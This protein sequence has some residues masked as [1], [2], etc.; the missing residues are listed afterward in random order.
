M[1]EEIWEKPGENPVYKLREIW[2]NSRMKS[3]EIYKNFIDLFKKLIIFL[4]VQFLRIEIHYTSKKK[5]LELSGN[6]YKIF[7]VA[8]SEEYTT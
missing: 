4:L 3:G 5:S 1:I 7:I 8:N 6:P 2:V